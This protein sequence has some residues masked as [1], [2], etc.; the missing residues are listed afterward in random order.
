MKQPLILLALAAL[1]GPTYAFTFESQEPLSTSRVI[2]RFVEDTPS[3]MFMAAEGAVPVRM[4]GESPKWWLF[5]T[6]SVADAQ[7]LTAE[8]QNS[9][10]VAFAAV[11]TYV[12][13]QRDAFVPNDPYYLPVSGSS[14]QWHL[15]NT[16]VAGRDI[17]VVGAWNRDITGAGVFAGA[18]DD[19]AEHTHPDLNPNFSLTNS[20]DFGGND[21]DPM[22][23]TSDFH[24]TAVLGLIGARGGNGVGV[25]GVAPFANTFMLRIDFGVSTASDFI[26]ACAYRSTIS[27]PLLKVKNH[28]Y[29]PTST[30]TTD[31]GERAA[32]EDSAAAG[33]IH[34]R[35]AGNARNSSSEDSNRHEVRNSPWTIAVTALGSNGRFASYSSY[36]A[37]AVCTTPSSST[38]FLG[39][40]TTDRAGSNGYNGSNTFPDENYTTGFGGTS[41]AA[42]IAAG[43]FTLMKQVNPQADVRFARHL[44]ARTA[45]VVDATDASQTSDGGWKTNAAGYKFNPNYGFGL[46]DADA[47]TQ[48][49]AAWKR[50]T[51]SASESAGTINVAAAIPD[52]IPAGITRT[53]TVANPGLVEAVMIR[54]NVTHTY[55]GDIQAYIT[56]PSGTRH[57]IINSAPS[58]SANNFNMRFSANGFWG[59]QAQGTW[60]IQLV[61]T[62]LAELG[63]WN[64]FAPTVYTGTLQRDLVG[65]VDLLDFSGTVAGRTVTVELVPTGGGSSLVFTPT[66]DASGNFTIPVS[67]S[68]N[69]DVF[70]KA[71]HWLRKQVNLDFDSANVN[72]DVDLINGDADGDN[73][74]GSGDLS[75]LSGA[76]LTAS[77]DPGYLDAADLDGDGE[78][79]SSDLSILSANFLIAG[80]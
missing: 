56:S 5:E 60:S 42:P 71:S 52:G 20:F 73:E 53:W 10:R 78:I 22:P 26:D 33:T 80:D 72:L 77:G 59:E 24:G 57:R 8:L 35:S 27:N 12:Y 44:V 51:P 67:I 47:L 18:V 9:P 15:F 6:G 68:G 62:D 14:G 58:D 36:G 76:F 11:D 41:G 37:H 66:L 16:M 4:L 75:L 23:G 64:S 61:D 43:V 29:G 63:S 40:L 17:N 3:P 32:M 39:L 70:V 50:V 13:N 49:A 1:A 31:S 2:V 45:K 79:G 30:F 65:H 55:R 74:V 7:R 69:Y 19:G 54:L 38:G 25:T 21:A 34:T 46:L 28:S 48:A